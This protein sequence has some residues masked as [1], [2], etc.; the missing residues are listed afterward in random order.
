MAELS[1]AAGSS[2]S[3]QQKGAETYRMVKSRS[4]TDA[5]GAQRHTPPAVTCDEIPALGLQPTG[6]LV[7]QSFGDYKLLAEIGR[8]GMGIVY[9]A[10][11]QSV[12]RLVAL[13]MLLADPSRNPSL[14]A[15]F[16]SE[17]RLAGSLSHRNI[18]SVYNVGECPF[19]HYFAMEFIDGHCLENILQ[20]RTVPIPW[21]VSLLI[22][23]AEAVHYA[24]TRGVIHRDL[25]PANIMIDRTRRPVV[26]D[27]GTAKFLGQSSNLTVE[28]TIIGTPAYMPP[29][30]AGESTHPV[31]PHSDIYS[32]GAILYTLLSGRPPFN[33]STALRTILKVL[34]SEMPPPLREL[35]YDTPVRLEEICMRC[36]SKTPGDRYS[37]ARDLGMELRRFRNDT[38]QKRSSFSLRTL[39]PSV[40]L[41]S[42]P[43]G[44]EIRLFHPTTVIGRASD[45]E[46]VLRVPEVSKHHCQILLKANQVIVEDLDSVNGICVNGERIKSA[47]LHDG[48][49]LDIAGQIFHIRVQTSSSRPAKE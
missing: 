38:A 19:G 40:T 24:H 10:H 31:G 21:A 9:K 42:K 18:V 49:R 5:A 1:K 36:L 41:V 2:E 22:V 43:R 13:K 48:D 46:I 12:D 7:G 15:R 25:K 34:S 20:E 45:C 39:L 33:E 16:L 32:L 17:V 47:E 27:F 35:R 30:Q 28:G 26:M 23:L 14:V 8:G 6:S 4:D 11:Q 3:L 37:S 44:K 29:E